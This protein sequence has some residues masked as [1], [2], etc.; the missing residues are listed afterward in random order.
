[1][2]RTE[3]LGGGDA[4]GFRALFGVLATKEEGRVFGQRRAE[5]G[6]VTLRQKS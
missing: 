2:E 3:I 4:E 1:M 6:G 5:S